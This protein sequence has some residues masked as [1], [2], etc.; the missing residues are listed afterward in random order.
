VND[1]ADPATRRSARPAAVILIAHG[2]RNP[3]AQADHQLLCERVADRTGAGVRAAYLELAEPSI[4]NAIDGAV[5]EGATRVR[6]VPLFLHTGNHVARDIPEIVE[7]AR[8]RH[9]DI[10]IELETHVGA[11]P[12]L[13][14]LVA[15]RIG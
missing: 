4:P 1:H 14:D 7:A 6:L 8:L 10:D 11:D 3:A 12:G 2:S 15:E 5:G 9:P 13:V